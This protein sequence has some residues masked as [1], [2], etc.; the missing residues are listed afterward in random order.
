M[1]LGVQ[2]L[3]F[4]IF[5]YLSTKNTKKRE[6]GTFYQFLPKKREVSTFYQFFSA[7]QRIADLSLK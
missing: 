3:K 6:V 7:V 4:A 1:I 2:K 5:L